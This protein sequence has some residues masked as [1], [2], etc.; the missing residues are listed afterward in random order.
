MS[1]QMCQKDVVIGLS[2]MDAGFRAWLVCSLV[3]LALAFGF[4]AFMFVTML[5]DRGLGLTMEKLWPLLVV[6][7]V[8]G[9]GLIVVLRG[10]RKLERW[11]REWRWTVAIISLIAF[12]V[13]CAVLLVI[14][15]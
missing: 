11:R 2:M 14:I 10:N 8:S 6:G 9:I 3:G 5:H 15:P 12:P 1:C 7:A 13:T 4:I